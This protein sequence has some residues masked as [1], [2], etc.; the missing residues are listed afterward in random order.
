MKTGLLSL[1]STM[2]MKTGSSAMRGGLPWSCARMVKFSHW[3]CSK[4]TVRLATIL[5]AKHTLLLSVWECLDWAVIG[6]GELVPR[7]VEGH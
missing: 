6:S 4:S 1:T 7:E 3:T 5:P 2:R